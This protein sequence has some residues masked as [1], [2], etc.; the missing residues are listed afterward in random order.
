MAQNIA[1]EREKLA[2]KLD[3]AALSSV[4]RAIG[5]LSG[6]RADLVAE[7]ADA[8]KDLKLAALSTIKGVESSMKSGSEAARMRGLV[9]LHKLLVESPTAFAKAAYLPDRALLDR[10]VLG[11]PEP[12]QSEAEESNRRR[13]AWQ[14][15]YT[16]VQ[17]DAG[18]VLG[19]YRAMQE[20]FGSDEGVIEPGNTAL[21]KKRQMVAEKLATEEAAAAQFDRT[22]RAFTE[23]PVVYAE[24]AAEQGLDP[25]SDEARRKFAVDM[26]LDTL[27]P[28]VQESGFI[29][30]LKNTVE[31]PKAFEDELARSD[32][33]EGIAAIDKELDYLKG[34]LPGERG[35]GPT[36][37]TDR[38]KLA[39]WI[40]REDTR[41]WAEQHGLKLG[42]TVPL[43]PELQKEIDEGK[44]PGSVYT[45]YG[46]YLPRPDD[47]VAYR[48]AKAEQNRRP[49]RQILRAFGT[50]RGA[51]SVVEVDLKPP[52]EL[53][54]KAKGPRLS[55]VAIYPGEGGAPAAVGKLADGTYVGSA[56]MS[57]WKPIPEEAAA[58]IEG[59]SFQPV[60][61]EQYP[62][63]KP[64]PTKTVRGVRRLSQYGDAPGSVRFVNPDTG[65]EEYIAPEDIAEK[66]E[67]GLAP[68]ARRPQPL[69]AVRKAQ[70]QGV[71][72]RT[73]LTEEQ[74]EPTLRQE[75]VSTPEDRPTPRQQAVEKLADNAA[76][77]T[78]LR[79]ADKA[80]EASRASVPL[81][82]VPAG[83][84]TPSAV[85]PAERTEP[86]NP[87]VPASPVVSSDE[88]AD[89]RK[90]FRK[91][92][93]S[94][95]GT[96]YAPPAE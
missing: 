16:Q 8:S 69:D 9:D 1:L 39:A 71:L 42:Q 51:Q 24:W 3:V 79:Q 12:G 49:E 15:F 14:A 47:M 76:A 59:L 63:A 89:Q 56:D 29:S 57:T 75:P 82:K 86:A 54:A 38:D 70:A 50:G 6:Q 72:K 95:A 10:I 20:Q 61:D 74:P 65:K 83:T 11:L 68:G 22:I 66:R 32:V 73:G 44:Y 17:P 31:D 46:V 80:V 64:L 13:A 26:G 2:S 87:V 28:A 30:R 4:V 85:T 18:N 78:V 55:E 35:E 23:R 52:D 27:L 36:A 53:V 5:Q 19:T 60:T 58:A 41:W 25:E 62:L 67:P 92:K 88:K 40:G 94:P 34:L 93:M 84:V 7:K 33:G 45:K 43:T 37:D 48:R 21:T 96:S 91:A 77:T 81:N 90:L